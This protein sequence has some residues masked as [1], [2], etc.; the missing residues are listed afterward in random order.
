[1]TDVLSHEDQDN[2]DEQA[3][4]RQVEGR[5]AERRGANPVGVC[6]GGEVD[7]AT[8]AG[9][10]VANQNTDEDREATDDALE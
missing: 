3:Y 7:L 5:G 8:D 10:C 1:M 2:R 9:G 6:D 4:Q